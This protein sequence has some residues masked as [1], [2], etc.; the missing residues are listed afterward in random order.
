MT[1]G[2]GVWILIIKG[3]LDAKDPSY[4]VSKHNNQVAPSRVAQSRVA[5]SRVAQSK[6][7]QSRVA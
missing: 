3:S 7:A 5:Q 2:C 6:V 4:E 1:V